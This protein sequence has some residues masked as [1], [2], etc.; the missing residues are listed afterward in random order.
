MKRSSSTEIAMP[1]YLTYSEKA[2]AQVDDATQA[3]IKALASEA[4]GWQPLGLG[5]YLHLGDADEVGGVIHVVGVPD[6][7]MA[8]MNVLLLA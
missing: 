5:T 4:I 8:D 7:N 1:A 3:E 6:A 2:L